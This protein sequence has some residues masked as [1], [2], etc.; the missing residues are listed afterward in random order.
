MQHAAATPLSLG[1][2]IGV[3]VEV[4]QGEAPEFGRQRI[5][6]SV[7]RQAQRA[8]ELDL[9]SASGCTSGN[10]TTKLVALERDHDVP[11]TNPPRAPRARSAVPHARERP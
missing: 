1:Q 9:H 6:P 5:G 8:L 3:V 2:P 4:P 11:L 7:V 10:R